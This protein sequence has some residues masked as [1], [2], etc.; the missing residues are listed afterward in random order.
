MRLPGIVR[1]HPR[2]T[3]GILGLGLA[4]FVFGIIWFEPQ[5]LFLEDRVDE[6]PPGVAQAVGDS[7]PTDTATGDKKKGT[8]RSDAEPAGPQTIANGQFISLE[9]ESHGRALVVE[10]PDGSRFLRFEDFSTSNG[11]DL[12]V[13]LSSKPAT[14]DWYGYDADFVD[15]G[16]LKGNIGNQ[17]YEIPEGTNLNRY[18]S[19]VVWC[20]R[21]T[22]GFAVAPL[23]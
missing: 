5:K 19:A 9:H 4:L 21:F 10:A 18:S 6:A 20:R 11:P 17:N 13:Y 22:V 1:R 7:E 3:L 23:E 2:V 15:L 8:K 14:D 16:E 12:V